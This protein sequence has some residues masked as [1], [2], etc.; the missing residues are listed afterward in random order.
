MSEVLSTLML[1]IRKGIYLGDKKNIDL[2]KFETEVKVDTYNYVDDNHPLHQLNI[3]TN[4]N[5]NKLSPLIIDIHGGG[6]IYGDKDTNGLLCMDFAKRGFIVMSMSYRLLPENKLIDMVQDIFASI[7]F[8]YSLNE[9]YP[10]DFSNV[11]MMGDSAGGSPTVN[12]TL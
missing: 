6:W 12:K 4:K 9:K 11:I 5:N 1:Q 10:I 2:Q 3:Y 8:L 7:N